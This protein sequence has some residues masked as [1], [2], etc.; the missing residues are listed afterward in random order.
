MNANSTS[1]T[2]VAHKPAHPLQAPFAISPLPPSN[3][4]PPPEPTHQQG[5][6][7]Q[8]P[9]SRS[10]ILV[11][12]QYANQDFLQGIARF[13]K[14]HNWHLITDMLHTGVLPKR[15]DGDGIL[16]FVPYQSDQP[17]FANGTK[18][19]NVTVSLAD[20]CRSIPRIEPN[21]F[22]IGKLAAKHLIEVGCQNF[23][24]A[25]FIDDPQN[26]ERFAGFRS[27]LKAFGYPCG[28]L[29]PP[30]AKSFQPWQENWTEWRQ[31]VLELLSKPQ[32]R[33]GL[34]SFNDCLSGEL[35][36]IAD[37]IG[38]CVPDQIAILGAGNETVECEASH[39]SLSSVD[40][41]MEDMAY[42]AAALLS[43]LMDG[44]RCETE[45]IRIAPRKV[46]AR[47]ST[48]VSSRN[49]PRIHRAMT[50]IA[51]NY[52]DPNLGVN[53]VSDALG[54]SR[55][56]LERDFR[57]EKG[58]TIREHIEETRMR[59]ATRL[60]V[61]R[62]DDTVEDIARRVGISSPGSF[63]RTFRKRYGLTPSEFRSG[64]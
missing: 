6:T 24:W 37:E 28:Q 30:H 51:E 4:R 42:Q 43:D 8:S 63:F 45:C 25:P 54:I 12:A 61:E 29:P 7:R 39:V 56:Q 57:A 35:L 38:L 33:I 47:T 58:K 48:E 13:A 22:E 41:N 17:S 27:A 50:F 3:K 40:P 18:V 64:A 60:L 52:S 2:F 5:R 32:D 34:F 15:W 10:K 55:R 23:L 26:Q 21:H 53:P 1:S 9:A 62:R 49:N 16:A 14:E 11:A 46:E 20:D 36:T 31:S 59:A 19:P 44:K